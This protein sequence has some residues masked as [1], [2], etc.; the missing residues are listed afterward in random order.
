[1]SLDGIFRPR[2][3]YATS[4]SV[5]RERTERISLT[6]DAIRIEHDKGKERGGQDGPPHHE[7]HPFEEAL[8]ALLELEFDLVFE[9]GVAYQLIF[10]PISQCFEVWDPVK[11]APM[12]RL[13]PE[14][15]FKLTEK[16]GYLGSCMED[17][18]A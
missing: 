9:D 15:F 11:Q 18:I 8:K 14:A 1:M 7:A 13:K 12:L 10:N 2:N 6:Q 5:A 17:R 4:E 3:I 16:L